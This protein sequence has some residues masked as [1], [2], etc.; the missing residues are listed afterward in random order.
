M[1]QDSRWWLSIPT[2]NPSAPKIGVA[3]VLM[4]VP[5]VVLARYIGRHGS[6]ESEWERPVDR[7]DRTR[8]NC[9]P[10]CDGPAAVS[11]SHWGRHHSQSTKDV[12][13]TTFLTTKELMKGPDCC[14]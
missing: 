6:P 9:R 3:V 1:T 4:A 14:W 7:A 5:A 10:R 13:R 11:S 8:N 2:R 12:S